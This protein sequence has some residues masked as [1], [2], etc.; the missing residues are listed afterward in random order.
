MSPETN[1]AL[2]GVGGALIVLIANWGWESYH[3]CKTRKR[4]R[5]ILRLEDMVK[6][7]EQDD[8]SGSEKVNAVQ[9]KVSAILSQGNPLRAKRTRQRHGTGE[10]EEGSA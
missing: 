4:I 6:L 9:S 7:K 3:E 10:L 5:T 8:Y 1:A 2:I